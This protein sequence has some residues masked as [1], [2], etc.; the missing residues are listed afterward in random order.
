[1]SSPSSLAGTGVLIAAGTHDPY[2]SEAATQR[3]GQV[4]ADAGA[5]VTINVA[6]AAH[7]LVERD[8]L[9]AEEWLGRSTPG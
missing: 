3:L 2:A 7:E 8:V 5:A 9:V 4:L 6:E 1:M